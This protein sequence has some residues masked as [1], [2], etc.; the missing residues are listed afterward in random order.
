M[1]LGLLK[2]REKELFIELAKHLVLVDGENSKEEQQMISN[3]CK[4][5]RIS[6]V[7]ESN[8]V[9]GE[10]I[11]TELAQISTIQS[12]KII[13]FE[14]LGLALVDGRYDEKEQEMLQK[15]NEYFGIADDFGRKCEELITG[16]IKFQ[17]E[18]AE[19]VLK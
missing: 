15:M 9:T 4:E 16:Y 7:K 1:Y 14:L 3:Y 11:I 8:E 17:K 13:S 2:A 19:V 18:I 6:Y 10:E 12:K 5:M